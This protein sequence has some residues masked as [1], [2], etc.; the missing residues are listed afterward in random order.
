MYFFLNLSVTFYMTMF[1]C[2][3]KILDEPDVQCRSGAGKPPMGL[4]GYE[5]LLEHNHAHFFLCCPWP[6]C[7]NFTTEETRQVLQISQS[8]NIDDLTHYRKC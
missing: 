5:V 3:G 4:L 7:Y 1:F 8:K 6:L 2:N